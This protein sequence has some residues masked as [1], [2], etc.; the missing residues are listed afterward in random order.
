MQEPK[1]K[2][3]KPK[4]V[5]GKPLWQSNTSIACQSMAVLPGQLV[6]SKAGRD[7]G[8]LYLVLKS[9]DNLLL[10][11][12]GRS[13]TAENPKMKNRLHVQPVGRVAADL[14]ERIMK[15]EKLSPENIR[16]ALNAIL[17]ETQG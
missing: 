13:R 17:A 14:V 9:E 1:R 4:V 12:D 5:K 16:S 6:K 8:H 2:E 7:K 11:A 15:G 10:L 3:K